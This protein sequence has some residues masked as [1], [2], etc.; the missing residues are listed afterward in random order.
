MDWLFESLQNRVLFGP[1]RA[2]AAAEELARLGADRILV[3]ASAGAAARAEPLLQALAPITVG[4]FE[5][6]K[7]HCPIE[8]VEAAEAALRACGADGVLTI[9]GGSAIGVA[10]NLRLRTGVASLVLPTT[11]SGAEMTPIYGALVGT[12]K[13]T[14]RDPAAKPQTV[15]YDPTLTLALGRT[16]TAETGMNALAHCFEAFYPDPPNPLAALL[17]QEGI[18]ALFEGLPA[19]VAAP[20][21]LAGRTAALRGA[22]LGGLLVQL[23]GIRLHHRICHVLGGRYGA[24]HGASNSVMLPYVVALN[25]EAIRS[26][27]PDLEARLGGPI[28]TAVQRL[29]RSLGAPRSLAELGVQRADLGEIAHETL[30]KPPFNPTPVDAARLVE[31]LA[32]AWDGADA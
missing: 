32:Q 7:P 6:V 20:T 25:A 17:A 30:E 5:G 8:T 29:A 14:G 28:A 21:A 3:V 16:E 4:R 13:R 27:A 2:A 24:P 31:L 23:V 15:I 1:G 26:A 11:Y 12:E 10:K 19:S 22:F 18:L 9:G